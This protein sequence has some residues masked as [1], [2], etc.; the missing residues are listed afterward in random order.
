M[1]NIK[2]FKGL[3]YNTNTAGELE[4]LLAPPYDVISP[5]Q[6]DGLYNKNQHNIVRLILGKK[7]DSDSNG[8]NRYSRSAKDLES[9]IESGVLKKD[10]KEAIYVYAQTYNTQAG[11]KTRVG[12]IARKKL[13]DFGG[14]IVPHEK[15]LSGP[16][17]DRLNL[18]RACRC[19]FSQIFGLYT[20]SEKITDALLEEAIKAEPDM[21][22]TTDDGLRQRLWAVTNEAWIKKLKD[23]FEDKSI[24]IADGHHRYETALNYY[25]EQSAD[26][27]SS[28][29]IKYV[30]MY[31][32]NTESEG[33]TIFP[34]HRLIFNFK[35]FNRDD[36][37]SKLK[38]EFNVEEL[39]SSS[40]SRNDDA[41][42]IL[43]DKMANASTSAFGLYSGNG[44]YHFI[45]KK[46][47]TS[48]DPLERLDVG[49]LHTSILDKI[50]GV[51]TK[52]LA[53]G[54][55]LRYSQEIDNTAGKVDSGDFQL[56]FFLNA[57]PVEQMKMVT[58][59]GLK[60]PQ[61]STYFYP[62][63]VSGLVINPLY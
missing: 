58:D 48:E 11:S 45:T 33:L 60:M 23:A 15:T 19:N 27:N 10:E 6:Q 3:R 35:N 22:A 44:V 42:K 57:T 1:D 7:N 24:L 39:D 16:K 51:G 37:I 40:D 55:N 34:T 14:S 17:T 25:K 62:K 31:L 4:T 61:K 50:L 30:M 56:A 43:A 13:E 36:L 8:D 26:G 46:E 53:E 9:W 59:A 20:D 47:I 29:D 49:V 18:T 54:S 5:K 63:L 52:E 2:A 38:D 12:F 41:E 28:D 21:D 32:T